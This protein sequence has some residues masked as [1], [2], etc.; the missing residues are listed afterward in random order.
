MKKLIS[1]LLIIFFT[2]PAMAFLEKDKNEIDPAT[3]AKYEKFTNNLAKK[4]I[5]IVMSTDTP[6]VQIAN[7]KELFTENCELRYIGRF[8][9]GQYWKD[10]SESEQEAFIVAF[11]DSVIMNWA[12]KFNTF[13]GGRLDINSVNKSENPN[14]KDV[15]VNSKMIFK[16]GMKPAEV[17]WRER[18]NEENEVKAIDIII[19]GVSMAMTYRNEYRSFLQR[20]EGDVDALIISLNEKTE[21]LRKTFK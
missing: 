4:A 5:T 10:I 18:I 21:E 14:S 6:E 3:V 8:V 16:N 20:N 11:T 1:T 2:T 13:D 7:F 15:F 19:E 12:L 9:L 17:I